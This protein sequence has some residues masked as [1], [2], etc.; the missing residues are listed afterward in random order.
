MAE[1]VFAMSL[2]M[3]NHATTVARNLKQEVKST[4][5]EAQKMGTKFGKSI[6]ATRTSMGGLLSQMI[7]LKQLIILAFAYK[8]AMRF[9][10]FLGGLTKA[11]DTQE[12]AVYR[13]GE[14][15]AAFGNYTLLG[16]RALIKLAE[17]LQ[18]THGEADDLTLSNMALLASF[19]AERKEIELLTPL[20]IDF[21]KAKG[22]DM[23]TAFELAGKASVGYFGTLSR[24]GVILDESLS[25]EEKYAAFLKLL[26][27]YTGTSITLTDTYAGKVKKLGLSYGDMKEPMGKIIEDGL[28]Q[29][30]VLDTLATMIGKVTGWLKKWQPVL[31]DLAVRGFGILQRRLLELQAFIKSGVFIRWM[32]M[33]G[34]VFKVT[35]ASIMVTFTG[36]KHG[37]GYVIDAVEVAT[38]R[39]EKY[40]T[41]LMKGGGSEEYAA[42]SKKAADATDKFWDRVD[43][44][45]TE[46]VK[47]AKKAAG[48]VKEGL[49][50]WSDAIDAEGPAKFR[51]RME[52][53]RR[54][55]LE[56]QKLQNE[57]ARDRFKNRQKEEAL[58]EKTLQLSKS[59]ATQFALASRLEQEQV[60][61]LLRK[62]QF[63]R[64]GD[65]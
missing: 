2:R 19:G 15:L 54:S 8:G 29:S 31:T 57:A 47:V 39:L 32:L 20:L 36:I 34:G 10:R 61:Y 5:V 56:L 38:A 60:K 27:H 21:A 37:L 35:G 65:V 42:A 64:A 12:Q 44:R 40:R 51:R 49:G 11:F 16:H 22:I 26:G 3:R 48:M 28:A 17:S 25:K 59:M 50:M 23:K 45:S 4:G 62:L 13:L 43:K 7:S 30:G 24:F 14:T 52:E 53:R 58:M 63:V 9:G 55:L 33:L 46:A 18:E 1:N 41:W 6:K